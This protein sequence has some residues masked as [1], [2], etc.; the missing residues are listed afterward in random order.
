MT[1]VYPVISRRSGGLS[2]GINLNPNNACNWHCLYCQVPGLSRGAGPNI[3]LVQLED[4]LRA[5]LD[6]AQHGN[7]YERYELPPEQRM[8]RDIAI[9]GNGEPTSSPEFASVIGLIGQ[10]CA[11]YELFGHIK[12][13][14][15]TNGSLIQ[16]PGVE[17]G[18]AHWSE[19]GGEVWFKL[20]SATTE[21]VRRI[22]GVNLTPEQVRRNLET[23]V[24]LCPTW[25]QTCLFAMDGLPPDTTEQQAYL[26]F[27]ASLAETGIKPEGVLL[28]GLARPSLQ[29]GAERLSPLPAAWLT[30]FGCKIEAL[31]LTVKVHQ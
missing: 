6:D 3:D 17:Q 14:L 29:P 27:L 24:G 30:S 31:G 18:L 13:V 21:G 26:D 7:F 9:S 4:E 2:I 19:L 10:L 12:L 8:I 23:C 1:Y 20:D 5:L 16:K 11:E 25:L 28:Y 22:N 15:I